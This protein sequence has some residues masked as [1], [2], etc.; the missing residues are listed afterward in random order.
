[1][2]IR[3]AHC[4]AAVSLFVCVPAAELESGAANPMARHVVT[5]HVVSQRYDY[6]NPWQKGDVKRSTATGCVVEGRR[7]L[8]TA[9]ALADHAFVE[10]KKRGESRK[11]KA[12]VIVKDYRCG[13]A[14]LSV[15]DEDFFSGLT[16]IPLAD[17]ILPGKAAKVYKWDEMGTL[18]EYTAEMTNSM[19]RFYEPVCCVLMHLF[20]TAMTE[21][22]SGEPVCVDGSLV[23]ITTGLSNETKTL[24]AISS[25]VVKRMLKDVADGKYEGIPFFWVESNAIESNKALREYLG[26]KEDES[27]VLITGISPGSSGDDVIKVNDVILSIDGIAIDD[28]GMY[29]SEFGK[30]YHYGI[31]QL[32]RFVGDKVTMRVLRDRARIDLSFTLKPVPENYSVIPF[33]SYDNP[34][35]YL[36]FGG[37]VFQE[38]CAGYLYTAGQ[39]WKKKADK[40]LLHYYDNA[41]SLTEK[42]DRKRI[43]ILSR[44]LADDINRGYQE[45][46]D[47]VLD[48]LDGVKIEDL[49]HCARLLQESNAPWAVFDFIGGTTVVIDRKAAFTG[50]R[51]LLKAYNIASPTQLGK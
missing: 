12:S 4:I 38:L 37:L 35:R 10:V 5:V 36:I 39:D 6:A 27:G 48:R 47:Q 18:K 33:S 28:S 30:L 49:T 14:L 43:I 22:G 46:R 25:R 40:R 23:G 34:P 51:N 8:T 26:M 9:Y 42:G 11:Y 21:G 44:V 16:P 31:L 29:A 32:D 50:M 45:L 3:L 24:Y 41:R 15:E 19:M 1:M 17:S 2:I 7:I 20:T 13:L